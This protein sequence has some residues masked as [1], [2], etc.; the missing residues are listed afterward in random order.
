M[1]D[2][3]NKLFLTEKEESGKKKLKIIVNRETRWK[4]FFISFIFAFGF[5]TVKNFI[6]ELSHAV[7]ILLSGGRIDSMSFSFDHGYVRWVENSVP[8]DS[9]AIVYIAGI[10]GE[11]IFI[12]LPGFLIFKHN[13]A[14]AFVALI[15]YWLMLPCLLS[16]FY[17]CGGSFYAE[18]QYF[19]PIGFSNYTG[20][21]RVLI[22]L[23]MLA[24]L[25]A[26]I[27]FAIRCTRILR[28]DHVYDPY[29]FNART[30]I[31]LFFLILLLVK[32]FIKI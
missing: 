29:N 26:G 14:N 30:V 1:L 32:I 4:Y 19:D 6:H 9:I 18:F 23:T 12:Y 13:H 25:L 17:W 21:P 5:N 10:I 20:I 24:P 8:V 15:G 3:T 27:W 22:G 7:I 16:L 28:K 11:F 31:S 2:T